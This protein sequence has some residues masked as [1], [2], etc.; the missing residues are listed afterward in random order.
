MKIVPKHRKGRDRWYLEKIEL[1][2]FT[3]QNEKQK[4]YFFGLNDWISSETD[5]FRDIPLS[6]GGRAL[7][8]ETSYRVTV[9]TS[10]VDGASSDANVF[11]VIFGQNGDSGQLELANSSTHMNKFERNN[12]DIFTFENILSLGELTKLRIWSDESSFF[13]SNWHLEYAKID[14]LKTGQ[15]YMFPCNKWLS[16][17]KGDGQ[18]VRELVCSNDSPGSSRRGSLTP[19][20]KIPYEIEITTSDKREAG[21]T[22]NGSIIIEGSKKKSERFYMKNTPRNKILRG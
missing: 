2:K 16:S 11:I 13:K 10:D 18:L 5:Y 6:K 7:I 14:D 17:K 15:S 9:K 22:Q 20:G 8:E 1:V 19:S 21:T 12:E 4:T 3:Q